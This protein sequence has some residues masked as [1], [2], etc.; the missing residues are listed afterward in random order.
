MMKVHDIVGGLAG[1]GISSY[2][3]IRGAKMPVDHIMKLGP[4]FFP[5]VLAVVL[6]GFSA[7]LVLQGALSKKPSDFDPIDFRSFGIWRV[8]L[9]LLAA[10]AYAVLLKPLGFIPVTIL[11]ILSLMLL[12]GSRRPLDLVLTPL[13]ATLGVW[14]VFER[15]LA[16]SLPLGLLSILGL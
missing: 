2:V 6:I 9:A 13:L 14:F 11:F 5:S 3:L 7:A 15:L 4:S 12:L 8:L 1:I 16:I 10:V